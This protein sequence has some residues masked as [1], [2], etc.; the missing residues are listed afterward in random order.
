MATAR[1]G[2]LVLAL[3]SGA[4]SAYELTI[5]H[6]NDHHSH[7]QR[8]KLDLELA[9]ERTRV[10][11]GGFAAATRA[12]AELGEGRANLL[13][14]HAGDAIT[15]DLYYTLFKGEADAVLMNTVCFDAFALGN[16]E[17]DEG[18]AG[19][20]R[21]L[22]HLR[23]G[24][25]NTPV[26]AANVRPE[27]GVSPLAR[28]GANQYLQPSVVL[29]RGGERIGIIGIDIAKKTK[30]SSNPDPTT[31]FLDETETAQAEIDRLQAEGVD[32]IILLT[33]I[34]YA[35]DVAMAPRLTG[36]DVIVGG[37]S[38]TLLG[39]GF[40]ALGLNP[41]GGYPTEVANADGD[42]VCIV[43]AW[44]YS[45]IVGELTVQFDD[46]GRVVSC[47]GTPHLL[48][49][50]S[51]KRKNAE[52][53]RVELEGDA[54]AAVIA[55]VEANAL[56]RMAPEDAGAKAML[57]QY[58]EK[59]DE[60]K[61]AVIGQAAATLCL[62][63]IPGQGRS[64]ACDVS[65]TAARGSDIT[66]V[67]ARGFLDMSNTSD[68][69]IQNGG[70]VRVD[71]LEGDIT[72]G[73]AYKLM[74]FAN[75]LTELTMTGA[76]VKQVLEEA[77]AFAIEEGGSTGA[78]P[79]ASGLRWTADRSKP[80]GSRISK[81]EVN[82]RLDGIWAPLDSSATY[83]VVTNSY[84]AGGKD[85]YETFGKVSKRG[86]ALNTYLDYAQS[87]VEYVKAKGTVKKLPVA[88]YSTQAFFDENGVQQK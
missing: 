57:A 21:F 63:R 62:E 37:D 41:G 74:P 9:G 16:H 77:F 1:I 38:H 60:L 46:A 88:E 51:F 29:E 14:L 49:A 48:L 43:Q 52:G 78:Y 36:V 32:K 86:D 69:A 15:G 10:A 34:Q 64:K 25:C 53:K 83:T 33:H 31:E 23:A 70:G 40:A 65:M 4:V 50:D 79:Y 84:I 58:S 39:T 27:V 3:A 72:I 13:E 44:E 2:A 71:I 59:V 45:N 55:E 7:L 26:L 67:V 19:L 54:R 30:L 81:L 35:N 56:L 22:D 18:D 68:F 5:L 73:D 85:G 42:K 47:S 8:N 76:E 6:V 20:V 24:D 87:F 66:N 61:K 12:F 28:T 82:P 75:T 17:F 11:S 80:K